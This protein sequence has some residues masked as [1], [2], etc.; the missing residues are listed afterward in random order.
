[1]KSVPKVPDLEQD[2]NK[3]NE[4]LLEDPKDAATIKSIK[5]M[6]NNFLSSIY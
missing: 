3:A 4:P 6:I 2:P 1:M 5:Q